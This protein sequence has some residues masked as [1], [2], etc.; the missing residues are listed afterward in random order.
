MKRYLRCPAVGGAVAAFVA[1]GLGS[2]VAGAGQVQTPWGDPDLQGMWTN[3]DPTP[4]EAPDPNNPAALAAAK[5][6]PPDPRVPQGGIAGGMASLY[7]GPVSPL[8]RSLVVDPPDGRV[9]L[10]RREKVDRAQEVRLMQDHWRHH[11]TWERCIS[12]GVTGRMLSRGI[13]GYNKSY[14]LL[15]TPG[16]VAILAEQI[17]E[18]RVIPVDGRP[19]VGSDIR[20]WLGDSRGRWDGQTLVIETTNFNDKGLEHGGG[21]QTEALRVVER[22]TRI[23][24]KTMEYRVTFD[25]PTVFTRPWA[26]S[27]IHNL[28]PEYIQHEYA[29]HE[30]N[31][32]FM[33]GSLEQGRLRDAQEAE[34]A[35]KH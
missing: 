28:D 10:I 31:W 27:A 21:R 11:S 30:G 7:F 5:A 3:W 34:A 9:P 15:Q 2:A 26:V 20:L 19:Q 16:T 13:G 12:M 32:R 23:D 1:I 25:D 35:G 22:F 14:R 6:P 24:A 29:C 8:R 33:E 18:A 17:H 4:F